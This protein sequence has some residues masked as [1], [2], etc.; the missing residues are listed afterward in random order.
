M[1]QT[2][3]SLPSN[4]RIRGLFGSSAGVRASLLMVLVL[5]AGLRLYGLR[6]QSL[7]NDEHYSRWTSAL[8]SLRDVIDKGA[9]RDVHPPGYAIL[10]H[11]FIRWLGDSEVMLRLPA[12]LTG[13]AAVYLMFH[14]GKLLH[15]ERV[16]VYSSA[17]SAVSGLALY[18]SQDCRAYSFLFA[19]TIVH[20]CLTILIARALS[21]GRRSL[22]LWFAYAIAGLFLAY[23][24]YFGL[25]WVTLVGLYLLAQVLR[26]RRQIG[27]WFLVHGVLALAYVPW[28][29]ALLGQ[30]RD[31]KSWMPKPTLHSM[32]RVASNVLNHHL[33]VW[34][35]LVILGAGVAFWSA[36]RGERLARDGAPET[37]RSLVQL[38]LWI[39]F[40]LATAVV[41][42]WTVTPVISPRNLIIV[43]PAAL[44]LLAW[45]LHVIDVRF[46]RGYPVLGALVVVT[47][48][49]DLLFVQRYYGVQTKRQFRQSAAYVWDVTQAMDTP[50]FIATEEVWEE[51]VAY[52][53]RDQRKRLKGTFD[54]AKYPHISAAA[55]QLNERLGKAK[56]EDVVFIASLTRGGS[57][58]PDTLSGYHE[59]SRKHFVG[60]EVRR[61]QRDHAHPLTDELRQDGELLPKEEPRPNDE[62]VNE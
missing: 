37:R 45:S 22:G 9:L 2:T 5:A 46:V 53:W 58:L 6:I 29:V 34:L 49:A 19:G 33:T 4:N 20:G 12:S 15:S 36:R 56:P 55:S 32:I 48:L 60:I 38:C 18:H 1:D 61:L 39:F 7:R 44:V 41:L 40:P 51:Y 14:L 47:A 50:P 13:I 26:K 3:V 31:G 25:L 28:L 8:E 11:Y 17:L 57:K 27:A 43:L 30:I 42:S 62:R 10:L 54:E 24:H 52:Y 16:G 23:L 35:A 59:L 21:E